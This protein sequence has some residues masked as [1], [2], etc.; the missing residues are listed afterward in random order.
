MLAMVKLKIM[1]RITEKKLNTL[2]NTWCRG[3]GCVISAAWTYS[4]YV[5]GIMEPPVFIVI[6]QMILLFVN[7][8]YY[9]TRI[10]LNYQKV[11]TTEKLSP[12]RNIRKGK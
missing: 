7:G 1:N 4:N 10:A 9:A 2:I 8:Q 3:P 11:V 6:L 5:Q 12:K